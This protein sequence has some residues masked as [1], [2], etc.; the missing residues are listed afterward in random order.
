[1]LVVGVVGDPAQLV[2]ELLILELL[3]AEDKPWG[4]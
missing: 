2:L 4:R 3:M 1:M